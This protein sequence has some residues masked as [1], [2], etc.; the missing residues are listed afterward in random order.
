MLDRAR[1]I[2]VDP[3]AC[4]NSPHPELLPR[5]VVWSATNAVMDTIGR[6]EYALMHRRGQ[7]KIDPDL[8]DGV[9]ADH[10]DLLAMILAQSVPMARSGFEAL[11][12]ALELPRPELAEL[13]LRAGAGTVGCADKRRLARHAE[14]SASREDMRNLLRK[15]PRQNNLTHLRFCDSRRLCRMRPSSK[16][17]PLATPVFPR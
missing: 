2:L 14:R 9:L 16:G 4:R 8:V 6:S 15:D 3:A 10:I 12:M 1:V 11:C 13:L 5:T 17:L 7:F